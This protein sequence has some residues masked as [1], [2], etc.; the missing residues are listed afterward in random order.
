MSSET[1]QLVEVGQASKDMEK[2][3][4]KK[5]KNEEKKNQKSVL[6]VEAKS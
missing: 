3:T 6:L 5:E 4:K 1:L 2:M